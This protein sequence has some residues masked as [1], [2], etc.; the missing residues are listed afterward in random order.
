MNSSTIYNKKFH[1]VYQINEITTGRKYIGVRSSNIEPT[2]DLGILYYSSSSNKDF[3]RQ[4]K[5]NKNNYEYIILSTFKTRKDAIKEEIRLH[6]LYD[7][8]VNENYI[9]KAKSSNDGFDVTGKV[10]V[11]DIDGNMHFINTT[12]ERYINGELKHVIHN[13]IYA[14]DVNGNKFRIYN[15]DER[16]KTGELEQGV[17]CRNVK[18]NCYIKCHKNDI[19]IQTGEFKLVT[20]YK[21]KK[22]CS[23][24]GIIFDNILEAA[25]LLDLSYDAVKWRIL[26]KSYTDCFYV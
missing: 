19:R 12:D 17:I 7:V 20:N 9:N 11:R 8:A 21:G 18:G 16:L 24:D 6:D 13:M 2:N 14:Y 25:E 5:E 26:S 22:K 3:I 23:I 15:D 10:L 1:Y 4:Q